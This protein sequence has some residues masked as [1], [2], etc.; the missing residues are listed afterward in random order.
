VQLTLL[1][2][3]QLHIYTQS[4]TAACTSH[5]P[6]HGVVAAVADVD[7]N[8]AVRCL[9]YGVAGVALQVVGALVEVT[10]ARDVV[11]VWSKGIDNTGNSDSRRMLV[12]NAL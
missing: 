1:Q 7:G 2:A 6:V 10:H 11:L 5:L 12:A 8:L 4:A 9:K 3:I